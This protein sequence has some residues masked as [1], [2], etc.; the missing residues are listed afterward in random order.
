MAPER[1]VFVGTYTAPGKSKGIYVMRQDPTTGALHHRLTVGD[2][3]NPSWVC[4]HP[5]RRFLFAVIETKEYEGQLSGG[6]A[7]YAIDQASGNLSLLSRQPSGGGDPCYLCVDPSGNF[8]LVANHESGTLGVLPI[9]ADGRLQPASHIVQHYGHGAHQ[10][11]EGPHAHCVMADPFGER[12]VVCDKGINKVMLYYLD[13]ESGTVRASD[14]PF[15]AMP[16][17]AGPRH[18]SFHPSGRFAYVNGEQNMTVNAC[19]YDVDTGELAVIQSE[20]TLPTGAPGDRHSTAQILVEPGG[21]YVYTSNRGN[22][23]LAIHAIDQETGRITLV[24]HQSTGGRTP[25]NF[26][27]DPT[28]RFLYAANQNSDTIVPFRID[29][30]TGR[31]TALDPVEVPNPVCIQFM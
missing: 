15:L 5:S 18:V 21:R 1:T 30:A 13:T 26:Q 12:I 9:E 31:L 20:P 27:T 11:H 23:S 2:I 16:P 24:G 10:Y 28:G 25:R 8:L 4:V 7:S 14:P 17:G 3:A 19:T 29:D 22:D 6:V